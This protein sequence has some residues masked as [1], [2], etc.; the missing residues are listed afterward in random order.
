LI[1]GELKKM[2]RILMKLEKVWR[3]RRWRW[4]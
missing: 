3:E 2:E 1:R 4:L